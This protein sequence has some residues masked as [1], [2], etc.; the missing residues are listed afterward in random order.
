ME[1]FFSTCTQVI[2]VLLLRL[3]LG[4]RFLLA[5]VITDTAKPLFGKPKKLSAHTAPT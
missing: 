1:A 2:P 3:T 5:E 4:E